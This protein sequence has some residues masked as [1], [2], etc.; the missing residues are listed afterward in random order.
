MR[1]SALALWLFCLFVTG[2]STAARAAVIVTPVGNP[3]YM[4]TDFHLFAAPIGTAATGY[5]EAAQ[6]EMALLPPPDHVPY[7]VLGIGP[8][9]PNA[10]PYDKEFATGVATNGFADATKFTTSHTSGPNR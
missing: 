9:A 3:S 5:A 1:R 6:T 7:P 8:G 2:A 4:P 10:G